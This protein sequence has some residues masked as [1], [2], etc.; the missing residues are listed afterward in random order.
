MKKINKLY[1]VLRILS[2]IIFRLSPRAFY[3]CATSNNNL[4]DNAQLWCIE[5]WIHENYPNL[6]VIRIE[7]DIMGG[8]VAPIKGWVGNS[9]LSYIMIKSIQI[10]Q[11]KGDMIF[12]S[13]GY[14]FVDHSSCWLNFCRIATMCKKTPFIIFPVTISFFNP[15]MEEIC[16]NALSK[17]E[18]VIILC[19]DE[20]SYLRS[21]RIFPNLKT[22]LYPDIV[23]SLIGEYDY[24]SKNSRDGFL[25][26]FRNDGENGYT[27]EQVDEL[28]NKLSKDN[29][30]EF[31][32]TTQVSA[33]Y[34][35]RKNRKEAIEEFLDYVSHY[36]VVIT[37]RYHGTIF[38]IISSTPVVVVKSIDHKLES[39]VKWY[40]E[41]FS[42][43]VVFAKSLEEAYAIAMS[44]N[45]E[46]TPDKPEK[47]FKEKYY[48]RLRDLIGEK[49]SI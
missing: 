5:K 40:P 10:S 35:L 16:K 33:K 28:A 43:R 26:I 1:S 3:V 11:R 12:G 14:H 4:G 9:L 49:F 19:R 46:A 20:E 42:N 25:M 17:C 45:S 44:F 36:K 39:G 2:K 29:N 22:V 24:S 48:D 31:A 38:S 6:K 37:D 27:K 15:W 7:C 47:Y 41:H 23:T 32:D 13:S 21:Q 18:N 8:A 30:V 34:D